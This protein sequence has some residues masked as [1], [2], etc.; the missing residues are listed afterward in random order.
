M[1]EESKR[2]IVNGR[3]Q[4]VRADRLSFASVV[5]FVYPQ[6]DHRDLQGCSVT[7]VRGPEGKPSGSLR[8]GEEVY[9]QP[10]M[11]F[12]VALTTGA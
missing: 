9:V 5:N 6:A 12:N 8:A 4:N 2:I 10:Y 1:H 11:V 3:C 7:F